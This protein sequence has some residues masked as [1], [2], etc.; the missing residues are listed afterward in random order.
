MSNAQEDA[1]I[2]ALV[3]RRKE[4]MTAL[5]RQ[6]SSASELGKRMEHLGR[7]LQT[8]PEFISAGQSGSIDYI[9]RLEGV[10]LD[11]MDEASLRALVQTIAKDSIELGRLQRDLEA[12]GLG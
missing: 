9:Q 1:A 7:M 3:R 2:G 6:K 4:L 12:K 11:G 10:P 8:R 5:T